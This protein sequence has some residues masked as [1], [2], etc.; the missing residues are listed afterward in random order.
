MVAVCVALLTALASVEY[1]VV[2]DFDAVES[3]NHVTTKT[4]DAC[5]GACTQGKAFFKLIKE[6]V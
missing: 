4:E 2:H 1:A 6:Y 3:G 5:K